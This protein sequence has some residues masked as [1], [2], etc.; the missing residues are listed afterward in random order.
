MFEKSNLLTPI[1]DQVWLLTPSGVVLVVATSR[2]L[3]ANALSP[4]DLNRYVLLLYLDMKNLETFS[5]LF[6]IAPFTQCPS[7]FCVLL[8]VCVWVYVSNNINVN[9][10][11]P[12][13]SLLYGSTIIKTTIFK[14]SVL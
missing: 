6:T 14:M 1:V 12:S 13:S 8:H 3:A 10:R 7:S 9:A 2:V 5:T 11:A 4:V